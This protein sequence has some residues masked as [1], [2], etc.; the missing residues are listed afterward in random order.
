MQK[1]NT[2]VMP[3][4]LNKI[5]LE[6]HYSKRDA[7]ILMDCDNEE[8][9]NTAQ[10]DSSVI[11]VKK[12]PES[13]ALI[14]EFLVYAQ[15]PRIITDM[16]NQL[17]KDNYEGFKSRRNDQTVWS[18]LTK[19]RGYRPFRGPSQW[20][21]PTSNGF[22][23]EIL[24]RSI[25]PITFCHHRM[26]LRA[27][28]II[29]LTPQII[30]VMKRVQTDKGL[31]PEEFRYGL[32]QVVKINVANLIGLYIDKATSSTLPANLPPVQ[33]IL[34]SCRELNLPETPALKEALSKMPNPLC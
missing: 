6:K 1:A 29:P 11:I 28:N 3:M 26:N 22:S 7:F 25:Y 14:D 33:E 27:D 30:S 20:T 8:I 19:K 21:P 32:P 15:D 31:I 18:L 34:D 5:L 10:I 4:A 9:A 13:V 12:S 16:P 17:G 2:D 24:T 23:K